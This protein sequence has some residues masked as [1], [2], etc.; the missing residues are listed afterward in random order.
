MGLIA[1]LD[2]VAAIARGAAASL[3]DIGAGVAQA[4]VKAAGVVIDDAAVTPAYVDAFTP[5]REL[6]VIARI[7]K[8]SLVN[9][10]VILL[11][12][13]LVLSAFLPWAVTPLL[14]LGGCYLAYE[15]A[16]KL[17]E[18]LGGQPHAEAPDKPATDAASFERE[19]VSSAVRTD[20]IL[21]AE[22]MAIALAEVAA[23]PLVERAVIL[24]LVGTGI[25]L[26]VY[27]TVGLIVKLDDIG[28]HLARRGG[29]MLRALGRGMVTGT[30]V[31]LRVLAGVGTAAMLWV[32]GGILLHGAAVLGWSL[33]AGWQHGAAHHVEQAAPGLAGAVLG[34]LTQA[35]LAGI[36]GLVMGLALVGALHVL[37]LRRSA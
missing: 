25:T 4:G 23:R 9:K 30:P 10:L 16:E 18:K 21:S 28:L 7:A 22:I 5:E 34:W 32:G 8:G 33:P 15:G 37:P 27:G 2:D 31:L 24:A 17:V 6:P 13:A 11:P 12:L 36:A 3:D 35:G 26:L 29:P 1:L 19:R 14:M 20:L